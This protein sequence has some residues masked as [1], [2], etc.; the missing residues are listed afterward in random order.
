MILAARFQ[1]SVVALLLACVAHC[2]TQGPQQS[3]GVLRIRLEDAR[4]AQPATAKDFW[5]IALGPIVTLLVSGVGAF[6]LKHLENRQ[7]QDQM[8]MEKQIDQQQARS[9]MLLEKALDQRQWTN[10]KLMERRFAVFDKMA[11]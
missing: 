10:Q 7:K 3:P 5:T 2:Q 9:D 8:R 6:Y 11:R 1:R 4:Q